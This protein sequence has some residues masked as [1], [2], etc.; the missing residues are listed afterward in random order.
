MGRPYV[1]LQ[2]VTYSN[3][4]AVL[5]LGPFVLLCTYEFGTFV[6]VVP[7]ILHVYLSQYIRLR[8]SMD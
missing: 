8:Y 2:F 6:R 3:Y 4:F 1:T 5:F 7:L